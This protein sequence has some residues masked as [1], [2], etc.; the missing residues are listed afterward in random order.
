MDFD[1]N[2]ADG[3]I[4]SDGT[5]RVPGGDSGCYSSPQ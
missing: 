5:M 3:T 1:T 2:T 4:D